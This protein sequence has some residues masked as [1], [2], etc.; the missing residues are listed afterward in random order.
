MRCHDPQFQSVFGDDTEKGGD[1]ISGER[2]L[3]ISKR[4]VINPLLLYV[5]VTSNSTSCIQLISTYI[6]LR[7]MIATTVVA[8]VKFKSSYLPPFIIYSTFFHDLCLYSSL[9]DMS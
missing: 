8:S 6:L 7:Q 9:D 2:I 1:L 3:K 4:E 5:A